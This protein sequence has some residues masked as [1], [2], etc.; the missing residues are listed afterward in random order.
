MSNFLRGIGSVFNLFPQTDYMA[1]VPKKGEI[2]RRAT[3]R[4]SSDFNLAFN[5]QAELVDGR[6]YLKKV[7]KGISAQ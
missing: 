7:K 3:E 4:F 6:A 2:H 1:M 5:Q